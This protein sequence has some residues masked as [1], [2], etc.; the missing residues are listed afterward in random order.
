MSASGTGYRMRRR[1]LCQFC[2]DGCHAFT[3]LRGKAC[4]RHVKT[5]L[6][7]AL[8]SAY[9]HGTHHLKTDTALAVILLAAALLHGGCER[10]APRDDV[11]PPRVVSFSPA[12]TEMMFDMGLGDHVVGVTRYCILPEGVQR[13]VVGSQLNIRAEPILAVNPDVLLTQTARKH[14]ETVR[15]LSPDICIAH[16]RIETLA[17]I[18]SAMARIAEIVGRPDVGR[19]AKAEFL[20]KLKNV[21]KRAAGLD[22]PRVMFVTGYKN[23]LAAGKAT[24]INELIELAG[25]VNAA[26]EKYSGWKRA[27]IESILKLAP[28]VIVCEADPATE[29]EARRYFENLTAS[30]GRKTRV[31]TVTDRRWTIPTGWIADHAAGRMAEF[32]HPELRTGGGE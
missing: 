22:R 29:A 16:F 6:S 11:P 21:R 5:C 10:P 31:Y 20:A 7:T 18:G 17:D 25:G 32:T 9:K 30:G 1:V 3:R 13:P 23:P 4:R 2:F 8:R 26:G 28:D 14:F 12:I 24:F 15:K 27:S 19:R